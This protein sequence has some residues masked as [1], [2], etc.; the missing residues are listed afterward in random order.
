MDTL[1]NFYDFY[2]P[3]L[4]KIRVAKHIDSRELRN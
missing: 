2:R 3:Q 1:K 4:T